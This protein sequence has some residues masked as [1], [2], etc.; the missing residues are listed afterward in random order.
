MIGGPALVARGF[1]PSLLACCFY[2][3]ILA[4]EPLKRF[5]V[6]LLTD[7]LFAAT[8]YVLMLEGARFGGER[9]PGINIVRYPGP[10]IDLSGKRRLPKGF[11]QYLLAMPASVG[12]LMPCAL[13]LGS[14]IWGDDRLMQATCLVPYI[15][16]LLSQIWM[17]GYFTKKGAYM[18][19]MVPIVHMYYRMTQ[20]ARGFALNAAMAGPSHVFLVLALLALV[21]VFNIA[22]VI[23]WMPWLYRWQYQPT[24]E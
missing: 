20:L 17:E 15:G 12:L 23:V 16:T 13:V 14:L 10:W 21:W 1:L 4:A 18:W 5:T 6:F 8:S 19:P 9:N 3:E 7:A 2:K 22:A 11:K 24:K